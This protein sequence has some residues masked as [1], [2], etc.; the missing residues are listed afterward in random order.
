MRIKPFQSQKN[1]GIFY[2]FDQI[3]VSRVPLYIGYFQ[4]GMKEHLKLRLH[5]L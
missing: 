3:K 5:S 2:I 4:I 1:D